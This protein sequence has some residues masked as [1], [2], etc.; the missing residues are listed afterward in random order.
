MC[1]GTGTGACIKKV[2][3]HLQKLVE[4]FSMG[5]REKRIDEPAPKKKGRRKPVP[6]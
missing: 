5:L 2:V 3:P 4:V 1:R 6:A